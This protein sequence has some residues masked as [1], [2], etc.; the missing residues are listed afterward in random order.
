VVSGGIWPGRTSTEVSPGLAC[1]DRGAARPGR[2][3]RGLSRVISLGTE[4]T[5][6]LRAARFRAVCR[7]AARCHRHLDQIDMIWS[8]CAVTARVT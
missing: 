1:A 6:G 8:R 2:V 3:P 4:S 5:A 7:Q